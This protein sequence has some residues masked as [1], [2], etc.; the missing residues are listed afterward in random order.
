MTTAL[1]ELVLEDVESLLPPGAKAASGDR[2]LRQ[3]AQRLR[4]IGPRVPA[5]AALAGALE[6]LAEDS[7]REG[8]SASLDLLR[9]VRPLRASRAGAGVAGPL[10]A[11]PDSGPW[12]T[13][14]TA[15]EMEPVLRWLRSRSWEDHWDDVEHFFRRHA[16]LRFVGPFLQRMAQGNG[17]PAESVASQLLPRYGPALLPDLCVL[18]EHGDQRTQPRALLAICQI[19]GQRGAELCR[20]R[21]SDS[22]STV[23]LSALEALVVATPD[24][25]RQVGLTWLQGRTSQGVRWK[26]WSCLRSLRPFPVRDLRTLLKV[27]PQGIDCGSAEVVASV[28]RA[29]VAPLTELLRSSDADTRAAAAAALGCL[30]KRA[31]AA[32]S[33][34][35]ELLDDPNERVLATVL[36]A[37]P[38]F[39]EAA[40]PAI[41]RLI[42][43]LKYKKSMY[44]IPLKARH[45]LSKLADGDATMMA[46]IIAG[47][48]DPDFFVMHDALSRITELGP[49]AAAAVPRLV[50]LYRSRRAHWQL[51]RDILE[52]LAAIGPASE[53]ALPLLEK[54]LRDGEVRVRYAA[55]VALGM[56][57]P[58]GK[59]AAPVLLAA[60]HD[61]SD[62]WWWT[63][64]GLKAYQALGSLGPAAAAAIPDLAEAARTEFNPE[65]RRAAREALA[66]IRGNG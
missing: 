23:R 64:Y 45:A 34:L 42:E 46:A 6:Q 61:N 12:S 5:A 9:M 26:V 1:R 13:P 38:K 44:D 8:A 43:L 4:E 35:L 48:D 28:G 27:M 25:A 59:A 55:A 7:T 18:L 63:M 10:E 49:A 36:M 37:L 33:R 39:G 21:L 40:R 41:P 53:T 19:D 31:T 47:L 15:D 17:D 51:R 54:A 56:I 50:A 60:M 20:P 30:G 14:A 22:N 24:E 2:R 29:A 3:A 65:R 11:L 57:G 62:A 32:V 66:L 58:A 52:A 16:E